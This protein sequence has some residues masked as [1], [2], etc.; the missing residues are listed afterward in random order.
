MISNSVL[1]KL[2]FHKVLQYISR[3]CTTEN[4]KK[5]ILL[6]IPFDQLSQI[7]AE[8]N[9]VSEAKEI[10]IKNI[11]PP[12][13]YLTDLSETISKS[14][15]EG[16]AI[17][18]KK[19]L[20][21][22][23]LAVISRNLASYLK[24]N[25]ETAP[26]LSK[27]SQILFSDKLFEHSIKKVINENGEV[28][29]N[30]SVKLSEIRKEIRRTNDELIRSVNRIIKSLNEKDI[31]RED[32]LTLRDG[33]IVIPVKAEHKRHIRGFIH[34][35]SS[36]GQTVYIEPEETLE[37]NN[38]IVSLSFAEKREI[39]RLLRELTKRIGTVA[40]DLK[41]SLETISYVDTVFARAKYSIEVIGAFPLI[42]NSKDFNILDARHP[43]LLTR[44][45]AGGKE[46]IVPLNISIGNKKVIL[47]TGPNAGGKT[48][49]LKS[50]GLLIL[51]VQSGIHVPCSPDSNFHFFKNVLLDIGDQQSIE[52]D[53]STFS[54]HLSNI[55]EILRLAD[56][57]SLIILDEIGTGTDPA[58]GS[59]LAAATL[60]SLR[61]KNATVLATTHHGNL[62]L[63]ANDLEGFENAA[64]EFDTENLKPTYLFKQGIPG[65]SYAFE[66]AKRIGLDESFLD[67]ASGYLDPDKHKVEKF[68]VEIETK[69]RSLE[70][71]LK[72][73]EIEN[74]RLSGLSKLYQ[75]NI[76]KLNKEK[77]QILKV[78]KQEADIY[79]KDVNRQIERVV[80]ELKESNAKAETI[81]SS[82]N[83]IKELKEKNKK[84]FTD[85]I[86]LNVENYKF[87]VGN[88]VTIKNTQTVGEIIELTQDKK[89]ALIKVGSIKIQAALTDLVL[90][91]K[92]TK[93]TE[94]FSG[95]GYLPAPVN[96]RLDIRG[97][98]AEGAEFEVIKFID[99]AY[100][101]GLDKIEILH[102]KGTGALKK[103]V[104]EVL[105]HHEKVKT[106]YF[107][108][109]EFGGDGITI[110][111]LN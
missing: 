110:A 83:L 41:D 18:S 78:A 92:E 8:G 55:N 23:G 72:K 85:D 94:S 70:D 90:T 22:L 54:S 53:L 104:S 49:V 98:R 96:I 74:S 40:K 58:E 47:I 10:L 97:E 105:K 38:E 11:Q 35:E 80:K 34:S 69:S 17:E 99:N 68:L 43:L 64:M 26:E 1:D 56:K 87:E 31:V 67:L 6:S 14:N 95:Y 106:F 3:Y 50:I 42:N 71:K 36:T 2:E 107:A 27:I 7:T 111:E 32:Y 86:D 81:K 59:A 76:E 45:L 21:I 109:I 37:L 88:N 29:D 63:I 89:K 46:N 48:V 91:K 57:N 15:I 52:D 28:N 101:S 73:L 103:T 75:E 77:K 19:I 108:P 79:L 62:K 93:K 39:E 25:S 51:L 9:L 84:L 65:S 16:A 5:N 44:Q 4:G 12:I 102:G 100:S 60:I 82:Q 66:V 33:R 24:S 30:A 61:D 20:E 13:E